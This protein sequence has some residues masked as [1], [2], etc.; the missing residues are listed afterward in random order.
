MPDLSEAEIAALAQ[1][2]GLTIPTEL[3]AEVGYSVNGIIEALDR[4]DRPG[5]TEIE[6]LPIILPGSPGDLS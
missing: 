2:A 1:A 4:V 6:P 5:L 3:L